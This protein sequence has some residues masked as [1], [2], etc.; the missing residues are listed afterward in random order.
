MLMSNWLVR[1]DDLIVHVKQ[2]IKGGE[3]GGG[4]TGMV[5]EERLERCRRVSTVVGN[6][7]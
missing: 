5:E 7:G 1:K 3:G 2:T 6:K 4:I